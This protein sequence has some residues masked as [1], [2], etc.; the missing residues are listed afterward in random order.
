MFLTHVTATSKIQLVT[1]SKNIS[2][3]MKEVPWWVV[4]GVWLPTKYLLLILNLCYIEKHEDCALSNS[5]HPFQNPVADAADLSQI[6]IPITEPPFAIVEKSNR[7]IGHPQTNRSIFSCMVFCISLCH[8]MFT[9]SS[10]SSTSRF[11]FHDWFEI[12]LDC[13]NGGHATIT[14]P[15]RKGYEQQ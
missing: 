1:H 2:S 14:T 6:W 13:T 12:F 10:C 15:N 7:P 11:F 4:C 9:C 8:T 5:I 3:T